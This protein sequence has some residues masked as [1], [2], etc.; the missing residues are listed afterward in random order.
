MKLVP[1]IEGKKIEIINDSKAY[2]EI[3]NKL[4]FPVEIY[5]RDPETGMVSHKPEPQEWILEMK[6]TQEEEQEREEAFF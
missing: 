3:H 2:S 4:H 6:T 1:P 5:S